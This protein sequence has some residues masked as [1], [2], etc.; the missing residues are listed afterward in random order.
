MLEAV[1]DLFAPARCFAC[2]MPGLALCAPCAAEL[3]P[4][5]ADSP[6]PGVERVLAPWEYDGAARAL[7][8]ALKLRGSRAAAAPLAAAMAE[9]LGRRGS[10]AAAITWVPG[11]RRD[12]RRRGFDHAELLARQV[13]ARSGVPR[14]PLLVRTRDNPDQT[15]LTRSARAQNLRNTFV[16]RRCF[17]T[18]LVVD[19]LVTTGAT[20]TACARA[21][22]VAGATRVDFLAACRA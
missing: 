1:L 12:I 8:L 11:R 9:N 22:R 21:L 3:K 20:A 5:L 17:G 7:I 19:D 10:A 13:S 6:V 15:S 18:V 14:L 4:P 2:G 16:A